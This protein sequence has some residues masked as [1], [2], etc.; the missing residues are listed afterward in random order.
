ME[1]ATIYNGYF[2]ITQLITYFTITKIIK[3]KTINANSNA[4]LYSI[5]AFY[6]LIVFIFHAL[7]QSFVLPNELLQNLDKGS[8]FI[9]YDYYIQ[10]S[11]KANKININFVSFIEGTLMIDILRHPISGILYYLS[12]YRLEE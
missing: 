11:L 1:Q 4:Y 10:E 3:V 7:L 6:A 8:S 9:N 2:I 5:Y 12:S